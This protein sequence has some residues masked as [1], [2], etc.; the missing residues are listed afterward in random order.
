MQPSLANIYTDFTQGSNALHWSI[1]NNP[2]WD[3]SPPN[4][5]QSTT[6]SK[7]RALL[8]SK[9][10]P[11]THTTQRTTSLTDLQNSHPARQQQSSQP[12]I[13][14]P[15]PVERSKAQPTVSALQHPELLKE[16][17]NELRIP[18]IPTFP[19]PS[20]SP[21]APSVIP[22]PLPPLPFPNTSNQVMLHNNPTPISYP[23]F[24]FNGQT[25]ATTGSSVPVS[26][27]HTETQYP[28]RPV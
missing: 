27:L 4:T 11:T 16:Q 12:I 23:F 20:F 15:R 7:I 19:F 21:D 2:A 1:P 5:V 8:L 6:H 24:V 13:E 18:M 10:N 9:R 26:G 14:R 3:W 28:P 25:Y 22:P 17:A